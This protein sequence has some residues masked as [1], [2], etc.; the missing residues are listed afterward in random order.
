MELMYALQGFGIPVD[1]ISVSFT[2]K[3]KEKY[4]KEWM[5]LRQVIED[6]RQ[7]RNS[8][9]ESPY[10]DDIIFRNG[11]SLLSHPGNV[12]LRSTIVE[13]CIR[14]ESKTK[15]TKDLVV[16]IISEMKSGSGQ[17]GRPHRFLIWNDKGWWKEVSPEN[18]QKE[19][20]SK[21]SR[22]VRNTRKMLRE[23]QGASNTWTG[24]DSKLDAPDQRSGGAYRFVQ[25]NGDARRKRQKMSSPRDCF[26]SDEQCFC[27]N[28]A[29]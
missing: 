14:Q 6:E 16:D 2:G 25:S 9:I 18:E 22:I 27:N 23:Q 1:Y 17:Q 11:T 15:N 24:S 21:I 4:V 5:R 29:S 28:F 8:L 7:N 20:H 13:I 10:L 19:L 26:G 3:V 12:T